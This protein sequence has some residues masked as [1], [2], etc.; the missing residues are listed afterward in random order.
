MYELTNGY[1]AK[2]CI[3]SSLK[4]SVQKFSDEVGFGYRLRME[5][6]GIGTKEC[7][8]VFCSYFLVSSQVHNLYK[9]RRILK[10]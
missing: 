8:S 9:N 10:I 3:T 4:T 7:C 6:V 2:H 1:A 5:K